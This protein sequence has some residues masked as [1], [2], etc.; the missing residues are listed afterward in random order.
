MKIEHKALNQE[1]TTIGFDC[2]IYLKD[3]INEW[4]VCDTENNVMAAFDKFDTVYIAVS[5]KKD[6]DGE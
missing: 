2:K 1:I 6:S 4:L 5:N 3:T